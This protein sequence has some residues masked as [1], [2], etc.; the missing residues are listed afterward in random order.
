MRITD[1]ISIHRLPE[2]RPNS[3]TNVWE[4]MEL[5]A[6]V[7]FHDDKFA[8]LVTLLTLVPQ[9]PSLRTVG[10]IVTGT[11]HQTQLALD[12]GI[13]GVLPQLLTHPRSSIQ[14]EAAWALSNVAAGPRQHIQQLIACG[15][16]PP[17]VAVLKNVSGPRGIP[18]KRLL[19]IGPC[20]Q[21]L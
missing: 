20:V 18:D 9:T 21:L 2:N 4:G 6:M 10:N 3:T 16:L 13:L 1:I 12:A 8:I 7:I 14:K 11:D 17:L 5:G 19:C 15:A